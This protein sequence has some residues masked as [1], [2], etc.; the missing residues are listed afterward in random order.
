MEKEIKYPIDIEGNK[1]KVGD[2]VKGFGSLRFND[3]WS[4][5]RTPV[6]TV[7]IQ[8]GVLYFGNLSAS[9]FTEGFIIVESA[10]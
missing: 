10:I 2:K 9:S 5:D 8:N 7:N 3:G 1:V 6:V 4:V